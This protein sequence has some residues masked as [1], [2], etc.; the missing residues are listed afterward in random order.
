MPTTTLFSSKSDTLVG[1]LGDAPL[2]GSR[3]SRGDSETA[4]NHVKN[5]VNYKMATSS[6]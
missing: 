3:E 6:K 4:M 5:I 1:S 2:G